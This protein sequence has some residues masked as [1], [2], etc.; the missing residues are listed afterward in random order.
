MPECLISNSTAFYVGN[1]S[2]STDDGQS[3][4]LE[5]PGQRQWQNSH[6]RKYLYD[7]PRTPSPPSS[8]DS[9][10]IIGNEAHVSGSFLRRP[11]SVDDGENHFPCVAC[12][13]VFF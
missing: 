6:D 10:E 12:F 8:T 1:S 7:I 2:F 11:H 3:V 5:S 9:V 4:S 13:Y